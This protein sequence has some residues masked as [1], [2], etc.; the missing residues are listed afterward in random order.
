MCTFFSTKHND[1]ASLVV[2]VA[3]G[4]VFLPH[5]LQKVFG[6]FG[7]PGIEGTIGFLG[8]MGVPSVIA[9]LVI[10][11]E[12]LG[13][14]GLIFGFLTRFCAASIALVMLGAVALVHAKN[15]FFLPMGFEYHILVLGMCLALLINGAGAWS[16]DGWI[17]TTFRKK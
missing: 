10:L 6:M 12:S 4:I 16:I 15:G 8:G 9:V 5:G 7:G 2:R 14:L 3:L 17:A 1:Y 13:A 11:A